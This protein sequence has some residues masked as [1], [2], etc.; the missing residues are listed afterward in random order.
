MPRADFVPALVVENEQNY[1]VIKKLSVYMMN[2]D[3]RDKIA[4]TLTF[5]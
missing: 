5:L 3:S 2:F 1:S 4:A